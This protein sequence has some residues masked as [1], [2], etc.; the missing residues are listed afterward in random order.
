[1]GLGVL[2]TQSTSV[3]ASSAVSWG[4]VGTSKVPLGSGQTEAAHGQGRP[5]TFSRADGGSLARA[6][7]AARL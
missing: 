3:S 6:C 4:P 2:S 5:A 7:W 1:M